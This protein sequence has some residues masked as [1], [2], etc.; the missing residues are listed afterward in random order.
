MTTT[1]QPMPG[2]EGPDLTL[3]QDTPTTVPADRTGAAAETVPRDGTAASGGGGLTDEDQDLV[4]SAAIMAGA[5]VSQAESGFFDTFRESFAASK[6]VRDAP[7]QI[8]DLLA[9]GGLPSMP[10]AGSREELAEAT[11]DM[12]RRA[13]D[14]LRAKAPDLVDA[15]RAT[16]LDSCRDVAAAADDTS[17][18]ES[19]ALSSIEQALA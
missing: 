2:S 8:R 19:A 4:R 15:Y 1:P 3:G 17:A 16:V 10:R 5:L 13:V 14:I 11:L 7:A 12:V 18:T 6:A 9:Q